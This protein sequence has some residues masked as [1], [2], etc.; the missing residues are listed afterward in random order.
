MDSFR[1]DVVWSVISL[2]FQSSLDP[3]P[4][5][6]RTPLR[7]LSHSLHLFT[8]PS[9]SQG[10]PRLCQQPRTPGQLLAPS[11]GLEGRCQAGPPAPS[12]ARLRAAVAELLH[13][14]RETQPPRRGSIPCQKGP[15]PPRKLKAL[16]SPLAAP[17]HAPLRGSRR[18]PGSPRPAPTR[19]AAVTRR[20]PG[21]SGAERPPAEEP[22]GQ[23]EGGGGAG[24][25]G[26]GGLGAVVRCRPLP[27][28]RERSRTTAP[29]LPRGGPAPR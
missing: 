18:N 29:R 19:A 8:F 10:R 22:R 3:Q 1:D 27:R 20:G 17:P 4:V 25:G 2:R 9:G 28:K 21:R 13:Q 5:F 15:C 7:A 16:G 26:R 23:S 11:P 6:T 14:R 24:G 12:R